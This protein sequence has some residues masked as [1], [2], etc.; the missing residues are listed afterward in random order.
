[1]NPSKQSWIKGL[2]HQAGVSDM[3]GSRKL[4]P[5]SKQ[6]AEGTNKRMQE[7]LPLGKSLERFVKESGMKKCFKGKVIG[8]TDCNNVERKWMNT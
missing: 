4:L 7:K 1:M 8:F 6:S 3:G 5:V 2:G